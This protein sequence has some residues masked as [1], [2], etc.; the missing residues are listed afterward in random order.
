MPHADASMRIQ[1][2]ITPATLGFRGHVIKDKFQVLAVARALFNSNGEYKK[3]CCFS[4][5]K[6]VHF[7]GKHWP[8]HR[9]KFNT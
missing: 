7:M 5:V 1:N 8:I 4:D 9:L 3:K 2:E 6:D